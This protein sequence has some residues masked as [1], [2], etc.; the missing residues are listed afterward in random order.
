MKHSYYEI[1]AT[2]SLK[3]DTM[4]F[5]ANILILNG[6][7]K[8]T[9]LLSDLSSTSGPTETASNITQAIS[10]LEKCEFN[11][12]IVDQSL[13]R[14]P[15]LKGLF[16]SLTSIIITGNDA[17]KLEEIVT[18]WP[19]NHYTDSIISP[20]YKKDHKEFLRI[21]HT[22]L[23]HSRLKLQIQNLHTTA[24]LS[25]VEVQEA[26]SQIK[27][28]KICIN[29]SIVTELEKR[30]AVES[31]YKWFLEEKKRNEDILKQLYLA[32][33]VT[34]L[35]DISHSIKELVNAQSI[36]IYIL[37]ANETLGKYLKP[38][39]WDNHILSF[40]EISTH[41]VPLD[42]LDFAAYTAV[43]GRAIMATDI[44]FNKG[45]SK[46]YREQLKFP[47]KSI[48][49]VPIKHDTEVIGVLEVY[50]KLT[51]NTDNMKPFSLDDQ[52]ILKKISEHISIAI[53]K[54]NL[55]QYDP[56]TGLLR[57]D[58]FINKV[59]QKLKSESKR[60]QEDISYAMVMGDV[61]WFKN[62]NDRNGHEAG[63]NLL[64][65]LAQ[66]LQSSI[67]EED[68]ICRYGGEEFLFFL[69]SISS[70]EEAL[71]ITERIR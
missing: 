7:P 51:R 39:L 69:P 42:S 65:E 58:P 52:E 38:L 1:G 49:S 48:L 31:K 21:L 47:M 26:F 14:Y 2:Q 34:N 35:L 10:L 66:I 12:L 41:N 40:P 27:K 20:F 16:K 70:R 61:D 45:F 71:I 43:S 8:E 18:E 50:N 13:G 11:V 44:V 54:L 36:S 24:E 33:D 17:D 63:N 28:L 6:S 29:D 68:L 3:N 67:R 9:E 56:L 23:V 22:A 62:Y 60:Q 30:L 55:I 57:P 59:T 4:P 46:R 37:D 32:N 15:L 25:E 64:R 19:E 5:R 53:T